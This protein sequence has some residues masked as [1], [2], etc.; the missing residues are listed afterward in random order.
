MS[1]PMMPPPEGMPPGAGIP[2][3]PLN[4]A[5][6]AMMQKSGAVN[7][8]GTFYE[9]LEGAFGIGPQ[10]SVE[11]GL[12]KFQAAS[13]NKDGL[14]KAQSMA[15]AMP[16]PGGMPP[17]PANQAPGMPQRPQPAGRPMA[18]QGGLES[19]MARG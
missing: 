10:D 6:S 1:S 7:P 12:Q 4:P 9:F 19:L 13:T 16:P 8:E 2:K 11:V 14:G 3:S 15:G 18:A 5:D 17:G